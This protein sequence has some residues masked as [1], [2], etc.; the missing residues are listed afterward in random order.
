MKKFV[1]ML[2]A[3]LVA[4][5]TS[6][7]FSSCN[8]S[9]TP[10]EIAMFTVKANVSYEGF[11]IEEEKVLEPLTK[12]E[13]VSGNMTESEARSKVDGAAIDMMY[14]STKLASML[15]NGQKVNIAFCLYRGG[16]PKGSPIYTKTVVISTMGAQIK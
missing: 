12:W 10:S 6:I 1:F 5:T 9:D 15:G 11:T 14:R 2:V 3:A 4:V 7:S 13:K 8:N 16:T